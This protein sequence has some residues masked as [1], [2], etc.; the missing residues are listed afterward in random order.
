MNRWKVVFCVIIIVILIGSCTKKKVSEEISGGDINANVTLTTTPSTAPN[1]FITNSPQIT[2]SANPY[3]GV[4]DDNKDNQKDDKLT[5]DQGTEQEKQRDGGDAIKQNNKEQIKNK[6]IQESKKVIQEYFLALGKKDLKVANNY[7]T[8][9]L[10][11]KGP[12]NIKQIYLLKVD[13]DI[14]NNQKIG[15]SLGQGKFTNY[16]DAICLQITYKIMYKNEN[17]ATESSGVKQKWFTLIKQA[18]TSPWKID[19]IGY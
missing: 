13:E 4:S 17:E 11:I 8:D 5:Q 6:K 15:Y 9:R 18:K 2:N 3:D 1:N 14:D 19:E 7:L 16:K 12:L 10:Q